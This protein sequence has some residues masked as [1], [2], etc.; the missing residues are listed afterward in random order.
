[1]LTLTV[2]HLRWCVCRRPFLPSAATATGHYRQYPDFPNQH[3]TTSFFDSTL[4]GLPI[5]HSHT[6]LKYQALHAAVEFG[7]LDIARLLV[8]MGAK[9]MNDLV[10]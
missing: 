10:F 2:D 9:V 7:R 8:A 1:M 6:T 4:T 5:D 3:S